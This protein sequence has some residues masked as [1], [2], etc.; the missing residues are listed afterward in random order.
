M[1]GLKFAVVEA[2]ADSHA[3]APT[4]LFRLRIQSLRPVHAILLRCQLQIEPRRR[5][6]RP[7]EQE[8][9]ADLFGDAPRWKDT[10]KPLI[11]SRSSFTVP[12]F[13]DSIETELAVACTYD[14]D[15]AAAK[16]L[17]ALEDGE[18]PVLF[19]FSGT[20]FAKEADGFRVEQV[21][22]DNEA[23][24]RMPVRLWR[25]L[26]NAF[27]PDCAWIRLRRESLDS[28]QRFRARNGLASWDEVLEALI[29]R[30]EAAAR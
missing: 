18:I 24:F 30:A 10:L 20:I 17:D 28:L 21:P 23:S 4:L 11:W 9:L 29:G 7:S 6:H 22:W 26:M 8:R 3:A 16:Y 15:V 12:A 2:R 14:F 27:F 25:D 5:P 1:T 13:D 19:L